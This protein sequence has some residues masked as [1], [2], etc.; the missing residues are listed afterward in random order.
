MDFRLDE[1]IGHLLR[2]AYQRAAANLTARI[3]V[4]DVTPVQFAVMARLWERGSATQNELGRLAAVDAPTA[5]GVVR[6]MMA[7]GLLAAEPVPGDRR[8][9]RLS[10]SASGEALFL[11]LVPAALDGMAA[12][13]EPLDAAEREQL[14]ALLRKLAE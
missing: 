7:R 3:A 11:R 13:L 4:H 14:A 10:L 12:T 9:R 6:R 5:H 2:R 1:Q 8:L